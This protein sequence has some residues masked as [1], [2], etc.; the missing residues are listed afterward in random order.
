MYSCGF[1]NETSYCASLTYCFL[2]KTAGAAC[3]MSMFLVRELT[4]FLKVV[5]MAGV[6][7]VRLCISRLTIPSLRTTSVRKMPPLSVSFSDGWGS[8]ESCEGG[9]REGGREGGKRGEGKE[10]EE[11]NKLTVWPKKLMSKIAHERRDQKVHITL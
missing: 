3:A 11:R 2:R 5:A 4:A 6:S 8:L 10:R 1:V 7:A 9:G